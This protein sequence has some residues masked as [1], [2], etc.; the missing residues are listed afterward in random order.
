[1]ASAHT[2]ELYCNAIGS[3]QI[4]DY[5]Y[6]IR[7]SCNVAPPWPTKLRVPFSNTHRHR[8]PCGNAC[9]FGTSAKQSRAPFFHSFARMP[10]HNNMSF[11]NQTYNCSAMAIGSTKYHTATRAASSHIILYPCLYSH[12][13]L[14]AAIRDR[15]RL[16]APP[17]QN[18]FPKKSRQ[19]RLV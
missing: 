13:V 1:M 3:R 5:F 17:T 10:L 6:R 11:R 15:P 18:R 19:T 12:H 2:L 14:L 7:T 8:G 9:G 16:P 4:R